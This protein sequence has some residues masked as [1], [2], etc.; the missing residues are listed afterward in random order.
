MRILSLNGQLVVIV[1]M[2][3]AGNV[4]TAAEIKASPHSDEGDCAI[5]HV[6]PAEKLR[7]WFAFGTN[8]KELKDDLNKVCLNCHT[9]EPRHAGGFF[10]TGIGHAVGK[11]PAIN[12]LNLPLA[13]D[14]TIT[15]ATTCHDVHSSS[16]DKQLKLK[17]LRLP[18]NSLCLSCHN[19]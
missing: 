14:G 12:R 7:S 17:R 16:D 4:C 3:L 6:A 8:K 10:G 11:K 18:V 19:V 1:L 13:T 2:L 5:C 9:V 15:C